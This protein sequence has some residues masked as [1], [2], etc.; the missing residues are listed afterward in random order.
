[1]SWTTVY[2][3]G[4]SDFRE[5]VLRKLEHSDIDFLPGYTATSSATGTNDMYW[6]DEKVDIRNFKAAIG[7]KLIWKY[8]LRFFTTLEAFLESEKNDR[9][10]FI[11]QE[12]EAESDAEAA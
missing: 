4:L 11:G 7:A 3:K 12:Q 2:I 6:V 1:M 5:E 8:R 10:K 9:L